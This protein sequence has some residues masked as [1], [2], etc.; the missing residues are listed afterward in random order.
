MY[1]ELKGKIYKFINN[2]EFCIDDKGVWSLDGLMVVSGNIFDVVAFAAT[3]T[4]FNFDL[5]TSTIS[6]VE[7]K[8]IQKDYYNK[9][10]SGIFDEEKKNLQKELEKIEQTKKILMQ[11]LAGYDF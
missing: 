2:S 10:V 5:D 9:V 6:K 11:K 4:K 7:I 1:N 8:S 3:Q